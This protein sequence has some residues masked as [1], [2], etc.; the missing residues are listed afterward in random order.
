MNE[1]SQVSED[2]AQRLLALGRQHVAESRQAVQV[3]VELMYLG[4]PN[5]HFQV[6]SVP[7]GP[8]LTTTPC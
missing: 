5:C 4:G 7:P 2:R 1:A 3:T 6:H 8:S